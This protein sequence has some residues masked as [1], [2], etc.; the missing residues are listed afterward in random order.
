MDPGR[1]A[2]LY[3]RVAAVPNETCQESCPPNTLEEVYLAHSEG[4]AAPSERGAPETHTVCRG[5]YPFTA[6]AGS[7]TNSSV[8]P[9]PRPRQYRSISPIRKRPPPYDPR[10][11][12]GIGLREGPSG[13]RFLLSEVLL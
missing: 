8:Q 11:T 6:H 4:A 12:L 9:L 2:A 13:V 1:A 5:V 7:C 10:T 3:K